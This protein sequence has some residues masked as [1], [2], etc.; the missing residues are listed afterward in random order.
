MKLLSAIK[1]VRFG[2]V[3]VFYAETTLTVDAIF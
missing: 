3:L 2:D 1:W